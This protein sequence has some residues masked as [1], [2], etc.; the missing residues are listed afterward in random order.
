MDD[1]KK[2]S[3]KMDDQKNDRKK[4]ARRDPSNPGNL[5]S[6]PL[7]I[8]PGSLKPQYQGS[9]EPIRAWLHS[10]IVPAGTV[11]DIYIY[12]NHVH[13]C[14]LRPRS[15]PMA[16]PRAVVIQTRHSSWTLT[17]CGIWQRILSWDSPHAATCTLYREPQLIS[18]DFMRCVLRHTAAS[19]PRRPGM[20]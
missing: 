16:R 10:T 18:H 8:L 11:A 7:R 2:R 14:T 15:V 12:V 4:E 20:R 17:I 13:T 3:K 9:Q 1:Y 6:W 19:G 5:A